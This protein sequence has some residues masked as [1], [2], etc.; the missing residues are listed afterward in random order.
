MAQLFHKTFPHLMGSQ[1]PRGTEPQRDPGKPPDYGAFSSL[2]V[3]L[4]SDVLPGPC[5][6]LHLPP[7]PAPPNVSQLVAANVHLW[8]MTP[9]KRAAGGGGHWPAPADPLASFLPR[10]PPSG[11]A[12]N[13]AQ[14][15]E[16]GTH[17]RSPQVRGH[18]ALSRMP[19][20]AKNQSHKCLLHQFSVPPARVL[21]A[22]FNFAGSL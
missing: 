13:V 19:S 2:P 14:R 4:G 10:Q 8:G 5:H 21:P 1:A 22:I 3:A 6:C 12:P 16:G 20:I 9:T 17:T 7:P 18:L 15:R 11:R